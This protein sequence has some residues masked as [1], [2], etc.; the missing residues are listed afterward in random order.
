M[1]MQSLTYL[2]PQG[3][4]VIWDRI[5]P[6]LK[7]PGSLRLLFLWCGLLI[8][9]A[10]IRAI[11]NFG[12]IYC[13]WSTGIK[14]VN[15][16]RYRLYQKLQRLSFGFYNTSRTGD[17]M[18]RLT[19]D[20]EAIRNFYAYQIEHRTQIYMFSII[21]TVLLFWSDWK[22]AL[23]CLAATPAA[24]GAIFFF[25]HKI[26]RA[27]KK[28]QV[29]AGT[30]NATVQENISGIR[31]VKAFAMEDAE[32]RKFRVENR[33][34]QECNLAVSKLQV[35]LHPFLALCS[36]LGTLAILWYGGTRVVQNSLSL[37]NLI[38][39]MSFLALLNFPIWILAQNINQMRQ[40][41]GAVMRIQELMEREEEIRPPAD[42]GI[43]IPKL[44]GGIAFTNVSFGYAGETILKGID[45]TVEHGEKVAIIG[46]T[47]SG[48]S[49]LINLIPRFYDPQGGQIYVDGVDLREFNLEWWR[50]QVGLVHQETFLFSATIY[51]N[52]AFGKPEAC[53]EEVRAA[54][55]AAQIDE[56][57]SSL[58]QGYE[59]IIGERGV[60]LSGGQKQ[61][62]AI[63]RALLMDPKVLILDDS[64]SSV[65][66]H[67]EQAIQES[68]RQLMAGRTAILITQRLSTAQLADRVV[69]LESGEIRDQGSHEELLDRDGFYQQ[70]YQIQT[71]Q[72][73]EA[74]EAS[75]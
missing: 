24:V 20:I 23:V 22:L 37:G 10:L 40:T 64:M 14:V 38:A 12:V 1:I 16:L 33:R 75:A 2:V 69:V 68:L 39:F 70:L 4:R 6:N 15:D 30:L 57:I 48:K 49:T 71:F 62:V 7:E 46:L 3:I 34:M 11:F 60:G 17:I 42:G 26:R 41:E 55:E 72:D 53:V 25:S 65:D 28:R 35:T 56:F 61:R 63:A 36:S 13:F 18:S 74:P 54:A 32:T 58:P 5:F 21:V 19:S 73:E 50:R 59:T 8:L 47:G 9:I 52:I 44:K 27:V 43:I 31:V 29:Q 51:D 67:T 66:V 45:L